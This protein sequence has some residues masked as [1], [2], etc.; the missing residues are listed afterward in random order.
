AADEAAEVGDRVLR[1]LGASDP[2][3]LVDRPLPELLVAQ[4]TVAADLA[5]EWSVRPRPGRFLP[6]A[7][8][9]GTASLPL[10][11]LVVLRERRVEPV[12]LI[13]GANLDE[14]RSL[15]GAGA[16][17]VG[18]RRWLGAIGAPD[19]DAVWS[20]YAARVGGSADAALAA[21]RTDLH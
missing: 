13:V 11:P 6:F 20:W 5:R 10:P 21:M 17:E 2:H 14:E 19:A 1:A 18:V 15:V 8:V 12:P 7:P 16:T 3:D 9:A 4:A